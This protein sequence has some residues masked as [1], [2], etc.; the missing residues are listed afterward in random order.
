M[1]QDS[2][3]EA[4]TNEA[5]ALV[6]QCHDVSGELR[7]LNRPGEIATAQKHTLP[8]ESALPAAVALER[9]YDQAQRKTHTLLTLSR[10][11]QSR[12]DLPRPIPM[13]KCDAASFEIGHPRRYRGQIADGDCEWCHWKT[14]GH[15]HPVGRSSGGGRADSPCLPATA[16]TGGALDDLRGAGV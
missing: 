9:T 12:G 2:A 16:G 11:N 1:N 14:A 3:A 4:R 8:F 10:L 5:L 7:A 15:H 6:R 13:S